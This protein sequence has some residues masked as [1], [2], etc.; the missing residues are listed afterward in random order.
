MMPVT[1]VARVAFGDLRVVCHAANR[2]R[3]LRDLDI[4]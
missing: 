3:G 1:T 4:N 2:L